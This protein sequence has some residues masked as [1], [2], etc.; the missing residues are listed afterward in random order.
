MWIIFLKPTAKEKTE[1]INAVKILA[2]KLDLRESV[3]RGMREEIR[4][5]F[6][7]D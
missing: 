5:D 2:E 1:R 3:I 4:S 6:G 7:K